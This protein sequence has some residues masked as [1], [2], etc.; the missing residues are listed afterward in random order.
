MF[1]PE[2]A[3][4]QDTDHLFPTNDLAD[5]ENN[6][7]LRR[8]GNPIALIKASHNVGAF[9]NDGPNHFRGLQPELNLA[10]EALI[11]VGNNI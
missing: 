11:S 10:V 1:E 3:L 4:F 2:Q 5:G 9:N 7:R 6:D 8:L